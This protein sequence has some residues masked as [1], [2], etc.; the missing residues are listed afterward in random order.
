MKA[1]EKTMKAKETVSL[2]RKE[3]E[4]CEIVGM[5]NTAISEISSTGTPYLLHSVHRK[6]TV[7]LSVR[8][9]LDNA[10]SSLNRA[11]ETLQKAQENGHINELDLSV[12]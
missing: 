3:M 7:I 2:F 4:L 8:Q 12:Y 6:L 11:M 5:C 10:I 1:K 9:D